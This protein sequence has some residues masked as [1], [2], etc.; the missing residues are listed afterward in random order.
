MGHAALLEDLRVQRGELVAH[1]GVGVLGLL[2]DE[3]DLLALLRQ[4]AAG[5]DAGEAM[6]ADHCLAVPFLGEVGH[7]G[8]R[9]HPAGVGDVVDV[10][11]AGRGAAGALDVPA[12]FGLGGAVAVC[13]RAAGEPGSAG[14]HGGHGTHADERAA[15]HALGCL[16]HSSHI[17]PWYRGVSVGVHRSSAGRS[18]RL[19]GLLVARLGAAPGPMMAPRA[20]REES[21]AWG[22]S[23]KAP[24]R[25][26]GR[27]K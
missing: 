24:S 16:L 14:G 15:G 3:D 10:H 7:L 27:W 20:A 8:R 2:L 18:G 4:L 25:K 6:A 22:I 5:G 13:R 19:P 17:L 11:I 23:R 12:V 9:G 1:G 26:W 21:S